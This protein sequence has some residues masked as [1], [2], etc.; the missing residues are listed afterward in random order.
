MSSGNSSQHGRSI[1]MTAQGCMIKD[2]RRAAV[3]TSWDFIFFLGSVTNTLMRFKGRIWGN[4][5]AGKSKKGPEQN[6]D[7]I[8][9]DGL[10]YL[11]DGDKRHLMSASKGHTLGF[12]LILHVSIQGDR[13]FSK[14]AMGTSWHGISDSP[15]SKN[16]LSENRITH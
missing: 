11:P 7:P 3:W 4:S 1:R 2:G 6:T 14:P 15:Q 8:A 9:E 5:F 16:G 10:M 13:H 12:S